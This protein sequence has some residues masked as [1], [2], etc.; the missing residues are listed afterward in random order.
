MSLHL[1]GK[2]ADSGTPQPPTVWQHG[3]DLV[4]RGWLVDPGTL[5]GVG[6]VPAGAAVVRIP[7]RI[8]PWFLSAMKT[9]ATSQPA[10]IDEPLI[11]ELIGLMDKV[12]ARIEAD[13]EEVVRRHVPRVKMAIQRLRTA[14]AYRYQRNS[15]EGNE[16]A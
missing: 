10:Q 15:L 3:D 6:E 14:L 13:E 4:I 9:D 8:L 5:D 16:P 12:T 7:E 11:A 2:D 1:I